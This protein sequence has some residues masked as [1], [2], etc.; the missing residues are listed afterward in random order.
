MKQHHSARTSF[1]LAILLFLYLGPTPALGQ[2]KNGFDLSAA[3]IPPEEILQ[4][5]PP[6]DGIP[7]INQ[8]QFV[9]PR[10]SGFLKMEDRVLGIVI[11]GEARAYPI[12]ILNWHEIVNDS[13]GDHHFVI[14]YCPL[15]GTGVAFSAV[16]KGEKLI[17]GV[18]GLLYNSDVLL[19][20]RKTESL[21]SQIMSEAV[22]GPFKGV[23][24]RR[25]PLHHTTW[26]EWLKRYP[27]TRVLSTNTGYIRDYARNPY[28]GYETS[29]RLYFDVAQTPPRTFHPKERVLGLQSGNVFKAYPFVELNKLRK[30]RFTDR[31]NGKSFT[32]LWNAESQSGSIQDHNGGEVPIIQ[33]FWFAWFAFHPETE[34][35]KSTQ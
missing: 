7:S 11:S 3:A 21:W 17:F 4:G 5:G 14:T 19:Y 32:V 1:L 18:S 26:K 13:I 27:G 31:V 6:R 34:V 22:A 8:P 23:Q 15:C 2:S 35:F 16:V 25:L 24:L 28:A 12:K 33:A 30:S 20:D 9:I 10:E 29:T